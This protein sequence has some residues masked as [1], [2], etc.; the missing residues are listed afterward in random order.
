M[1]RGASIEAPLFLIS[2]IALLIPQS[3]HEL[4]IHPLY[5]TTAAATGYWRVPI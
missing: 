1:K 2:Y 4:C 3:I 5:N